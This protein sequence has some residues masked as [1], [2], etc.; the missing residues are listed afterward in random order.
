MIHITGCE[1]FFVSQDANLWQEYW[2]VEIFLGYEGTKRQF[3]KHWQLEYGPH[4]IP[5]AR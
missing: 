2:E 4:L 5:F 1:S 3:L